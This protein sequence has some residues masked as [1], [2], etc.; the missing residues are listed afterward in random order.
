MDLPIFILL[1]LALLIGAGAG[2][3]FG[4]GLVP[5]EFPDT[6]RKRLRWVGVFAALWAVVL[7]LMQ[8][9]N[10]GPLLKGIVALTFAAMLVYSTIRGP[11]S[12]ELIRHAGC[13]GSGVLAFNGLI[14]TAVLAGVLQ[15]AGFEVELGSWE[16][17]ALVPVGLFVAL[18]VHGMRVIANTPPE[19]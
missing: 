4:W 18:R 7:G 16:L 14:F 6:A 11:S 2:I 17:V 1:E 19:S 5:A 15:W 8:A 10:E 12:L 3:A 13:F 9:G